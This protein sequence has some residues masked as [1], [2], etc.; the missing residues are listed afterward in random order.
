MN[1]QELFQFLNAP[2]FRVGDS[3]VS[4]LS[5][6]LAAAWLVAIVLFARI[7]RRRVL[8]RILERTK[9]DPGAQYA[10][11]HAI[12]YA[13]LFAGFL[14]GL[15]MLGID[16][17]SIAVILGALGLGIGFGLQGVAANFLSGLIILFQRPIKVGDRVDIGAELTGEV[18]KIRTINTVIR[19]NDNIDIIVPNAQITSERVTNWSYHDRRVR[20]RIPVGVSYGSDPRAVKQ[21]LLEAAASHSEALKH[22]APDVVF[23]GFGES[24]LDFELRVW[25]ERMIRR[26]GVFRSELNFAVWDTLKERGIEIPFPQR[27]LHLKSVGEDVRKTFRGSE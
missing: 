26:P 4:T 2:L 22:P 10:L 23:K 27:D 13:I 25:T 1:A 14:I 7:V 8:R 5:I 18:V 11:R 19:T 9:L 24:S 3:V 15:P 17:T 20:F 6:L 21:A 16:V 12:S